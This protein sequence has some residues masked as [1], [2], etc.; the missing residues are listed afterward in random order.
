[1]T[2]FNTNRDLS[3]T[4]SPS[5]ESWTDSDVCHISGGTASRIAIRRG[6]ATR[7]HENR[8]RVAGH[9]GNPYSS[10]VSPL[11]ARVEKGRLVIDEPTSLPKGTVVDLVVEIGR[12][13]CRERV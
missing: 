2:N 3:A 11:R 13:S 7:S 6:R 8:S 4:V 1:M 10:R 9:L 5:R 12:A